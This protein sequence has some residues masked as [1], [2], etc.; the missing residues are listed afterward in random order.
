MEKQFSVSIVGGCF[1]VVDVRSRQ[2]FKV[3][4]LGKR[5]IGACSCGRPEPAAQFYMC[6][7]QQAADE[8][9]NRNGWPAG[10]GRDSSATPSA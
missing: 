1:R 9:M 2:E 6:A 3:Q 7:H 5:D 8:M 4:K 10:P